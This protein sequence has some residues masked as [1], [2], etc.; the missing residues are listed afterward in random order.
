MNPDDCF[1]R[2][3]VLVTTRYA[4]SYLDSLEQV[5]TPAQ[6]G[7]PIPSPVDLPNPGIELGS[8]ALQVDSLPTVLSRKPTQIAHSLKIHANR[9]RKQRKFYNAHS[10]TILKKNPC[11]FHLPK[12]LSKHVQ[13]CD[14]FSQ[15]NFEGVIINW[16]TVPDH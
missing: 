4:V 14:D 13:K 9:S 12:N 11:L 1:L 6:S 16:N 5:S 15:T 7:W 8:L 3:D 2:A 10:K